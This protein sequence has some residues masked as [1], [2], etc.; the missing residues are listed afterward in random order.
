MRINRD[1]E[2]RN[3]TDLAITPPNEDEHETL[4]LFQDTTGGSAAVDLMRQADRV[5]VKVEAEAA[6]A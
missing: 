2:K 5:R 4:G 1:P 6:Q 3:Y